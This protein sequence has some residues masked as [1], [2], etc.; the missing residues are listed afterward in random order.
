MRINRQCHS[1][2]DL[3]DKPETCHKVWDRFLTSWVLDA[4]E[5]EDSDRTVDAAEVEAAIRKLDSLSWNPCQTVGE[6][7]ELRTGAEERMQGS[8][9]LLDGEIVHAGVTVLTA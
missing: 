7:R 9:L 2:L 1:C 6:G 8:V 5:A 4:L 3:F